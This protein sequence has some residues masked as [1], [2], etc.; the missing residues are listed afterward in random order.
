MVRSSAI[1]A[2]AAALGFGAASGTARAGE[3]YWDFSFSGPGVSGSGE[4]VTS[5][6]PDPT[7]LAP[8]AYDIL[9]IDGSVDGLP[10]IGLLG[11]TGAAEYSPDGYFIYD[12]DFY[13]QGSASSA[14]AY[15]DLDGLLFRTADDDYN[16]Y[17]DDGQYL[18]W[19]DNGSGVVVSFSA[20]DPP[21]PAIPEPSSLLLLASMMIGCAALRRL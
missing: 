3:M 20:V 14:G 12:N 11:G 18:D 15:F 13:P 6:T 16:L 7:A 10:I 19:A 5:G 8:D 21:P 4:L 1:L 2:V 9:S 17:F